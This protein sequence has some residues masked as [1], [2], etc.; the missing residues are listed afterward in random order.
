MLEKTIFHDFLIK[1]HQVKCIILIIFRLFQF[2][3]L[4]V[5]D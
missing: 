1:K 4:F 2:L 5:E 3:L